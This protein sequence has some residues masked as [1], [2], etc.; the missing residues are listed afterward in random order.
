MR[1]TNVVVSF[2][3]CC[4]CLLH[5]AT[6]QSFDARVNLVE[7]KSAGHQ[8]HSFSLPASN[9]IYT[10]FP[11]QDADSRAALTLFQISEQGVVTTTKPIVYEIGKKNYYD[12]VAIRRDRGDKEGGIPFS[13]RITITDTNNFSPTFPR[14]L[15]HGRVKEDSPK[16]TMVLGL[17]NCFAEDRDTGGIKSYSISGG[18]EKGY[19]KAEKAIVNNRVFLVLKTTNV[20]IVRDTTPEINLTVRADDD[21]FYGTTRV[22]IKILDANN[23]KPEFEEKSYTATISED[24]SLM[25]SV[26]RVRATDKDVGTNGGIY[27]YLSGSSSW[28]AVDAITGVVKVAGQLPNQ[29]QVSMNVIARDRGTPSNT[30]TVSVKININLISDYPP[31]DSTTPGVNTPPVFPEESYSA[32]VREDFPVNAALLVIHAVD[33]KN[34]YDLNVVATDGGASPQSATASLVVTVQ[35]MDKNRHAPVFISPTANKQQR[36]VSV[37]E[38][39]A[40]NTKVGSSISATDADG[41][42][43][44]DGQV[45]YSLASG[46]GLAYFKIDKSSGDLRTVTMLD[47]EKQAQ[48]NLLIEAR[49]KALYPQNSHLY[50]IITVTGEEDN[51]PDFSEPVY[52]A[53]VPGNAP[54]NTFVTLIHATDKDGDPVSYAIENPGSAFSIQTDSG[55]ISTS[56][57]LDPA[58][59]ERSFSL[60]VRATSGNKE[61]QAQVIV[62]VVSEENSPPT[63]VNLPYSATVPENLGR[64]DNLLCLAAKDGQGKPV[65][66]KIVS[67]TGGKFSVGANSGKNRLLTLI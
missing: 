20:R 11:A 25:T 34:K 61:S 45:V 33:L 40:A 31:A 1:G 5:T 58:N 48:Y 42:Q 23:N 54:R 57:R 27:Y 44:P 36:T 6:G 35:E 19:F 10:F 9:Q 26:L 28:F 37:R 41:S 15:Y 49:D 60:S 8:V 12:L 59:E 55:V 50:M 66:Y 22:S 62:T 2:L 14:N 47:R 16:N 32:N 30:A 39:S 29:P 52:Y 7:G 56:R 64:I 17:E 63:F 38:N 53:N 51:N 13:V 4:F 67:N 24:T 3:L 65:T 18:D 46:S 21:V 43:R